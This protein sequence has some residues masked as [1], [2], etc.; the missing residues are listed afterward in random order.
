[1]FEYQSKVQAESPTLNATDPI[2][3]AGAQFSYL[4]L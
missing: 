1:M 2:Y 3:G 4:W